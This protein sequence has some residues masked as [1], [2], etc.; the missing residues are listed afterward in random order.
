M[1]WGIFV[2]VV[3]PFF[4]FCKPL[5]A[6]LA[7]LQ[8]LV[9]LMLL[10]EQLLAQAAASSPVFQEKGTAELLQ[11]C[12]PGAVS[13]QFFLGKG[14]EFFG[15]PHCVGE[16]QWEDRLLEMGSARSFQGLVQGP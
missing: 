14:M 2:V 3:V 13:Q 9:F 4:S 10:V 5:S 12:T 8:Q 16:W 7:A 6:P 1:F 11:P 15:V